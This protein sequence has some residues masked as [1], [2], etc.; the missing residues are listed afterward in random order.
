MKEYLLLHKTKSY[1]S[2]IQK[3]FYLKTSLYLLPIFI[4]LFL[5]ACDDNKITLDD[6]IN[7]VRENCIESLTSDPD[8][9]WQVNNAE[10]GLGKEWHYEFDKEDVKV[11]YSKSFFFLIQKDAT[12]SKIS[13]SKIKKHIR[14]IYSCSGATPHLTTIERAYFLEDQY[15]KITH[16]KTEVLEGGKL[17]VAPTKED[18]FYDVLRHQE[19]YEREHQNK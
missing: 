7:D 14:T 11:L 8:D 19:I 9:K 17:V 10:Y 12:F 13:D 2:L 15:E 18:T 6:A 16:E 4:S 5:L 3:T 1:L